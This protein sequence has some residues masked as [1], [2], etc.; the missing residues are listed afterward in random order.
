MENS[1]WSTVYL[2]DICKDGRGYYGIGASAVEFNPNLLTYLRITDINDDGTLIYNDLKSVDEHNASDYLLKKNDI[3]FARTGNS[4]GRSYFY[5]ERDGEL[6]YAGFLIKF[7]INENKVNPKYIKHYTQSKI[8]FDWIR[9]YSTGSTRKNM[10]AKMY[11][12][13]PIIIPDRERQNK[14]VLI[15]ESVVNKIRLNN[16]I[17]ARLE[18]TAKALYQ[19]WFVNFN[20]PN[21]EGLPYKDNKGKFHETDLGEIPV[22]WESVNIY[23]NISEISK[24][25]KEEENIPVLSVISESKFVL[26]DDLFT[27]QV[28]S[29]SQKNY[30]I[31]SKYDIGF[32]PARANI[33]SIAMLREYEQGLLSPMYS[34]FRLN[35]NKVNVNFFYHYMKDSN[36]LNLVKHYAAEGSVRQHFKIVHLKNFPLILP[37]IHIQEK[38]SNEY[39]KIE[40]LITKN[41]IENDILVSIKTLLINKLMSGQIDVDELDINWDKLE[42]TLKE[43]E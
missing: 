12:D 13:M 4:T 30:K 38:F 2:K 26:S 27:K 28:Y 42:E 22:G 15:F 34:I 17:N 8:Y 9:S 41:K 1:I 7:N 19:E 31:I 36:F 39:E 14:I 23:D 3:V 21:E 33:G 5:E 37:P 16:L 43:I 11:G 32:N 20:F 25:N 35:K 40:G 6:V 29:K 24:K 18:S 10:N